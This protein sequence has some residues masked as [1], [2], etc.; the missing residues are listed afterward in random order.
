VP[1]FLLHFITILQISRFTK[2]LF[3][4]VFSF[5]MGTLC[6][7][8]NDHFQ[9]VPQEC[10]T[11]LVKQ[12]S[13]FCCDINQFLPLYSF[14]LLFY[15]FLSF[16]YLGFYLFLSCPKIFTFKFKLYVNCLFLSFFFYFLPLLYFT[17][18]FNSFYL[19]SKPIYLAF[20][21]LAT[22]YIGFK[23]N[24]FILRFRGLFLLLFS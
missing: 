2:W 13:L 21:F 20:C 4:N 3:I 11:F 23:Q 17:F 5:L 6:L 16:V 8:Q 18:V 10:S 15:K 12:E 9:N 7:S 22:N 1:I 14:S 24:L 19:L